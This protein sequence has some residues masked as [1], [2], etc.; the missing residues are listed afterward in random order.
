MYLSGESY[1]GVIVPKVAE[2][3]TELNKEPLTNSWLKIKL[4]GFILNNPCTLGD[5]CESNS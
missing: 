5:E 1:A 4:G 3:I 2:I